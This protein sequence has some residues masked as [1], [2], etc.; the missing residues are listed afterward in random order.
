MSVESGGDVSPDAS[1]EPSYSVKGDWAI[2]AISLHREWE[3]ITGLGD[4]I[5]G[6]NTAVERSDSSVRRQYRTFRKSSWRSSDD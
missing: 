3:P 6:A 1:V 4:Y 2:D 5:P